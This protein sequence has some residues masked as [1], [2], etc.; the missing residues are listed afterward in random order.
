[1]NYTVVRANR[2]VRS[3][4]DRQRHGSERTAT[5]LRFRQGR[6][7]C[8]R[9]M[10]IVM[11]CVAGAVVLSAGRV[12]V[13]SACNQSGRLQT[14]DCTNESRCG[15]AAYQ[16]HDGETDDSTHATSAVYRGRV[17]VIRRLSRKTPNT[18]IGL[19]LITTLTLGLSRTL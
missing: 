3:W 2:C 16:Q 10:T 1:L 13:A 12:L 6:A 15:N 14:R 11:P 9:V 4:D 17:T 7:E 19:K 18:G 8:R 5:L